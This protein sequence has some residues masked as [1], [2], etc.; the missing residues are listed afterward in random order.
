MVSQTLQ[1]KKLKDYV[2]MRSWNWHTLWGHNSEK[3]LPWGRG[4]MDWERTL[5]NFLE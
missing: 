1:R 5:G 3:W 2:Y 4:G